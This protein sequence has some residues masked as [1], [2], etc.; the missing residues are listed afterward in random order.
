MSTWS[1]FSRAILPTNAAWN[2]ARR[3][4]VV[5]PF[6]YSLSTLCGASTTVCAAPCERTYAE[7]C[8]PYVTIASAWR[9]RWRTG[10]YD[11]AWGS[12]RGCAHSDAHSTY[13]TRARRA[14]GGGGG[15]AA[16]REPPAPPAG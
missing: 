15:G 16:P 14:P 1:P 8:G 12:V 4:G 9:Y 5:G 6:Q 3:I 10:R 7:T 11:A 13:G 2:A